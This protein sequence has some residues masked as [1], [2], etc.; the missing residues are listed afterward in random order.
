MA[1]ASV[2]SGIR[3]PK[4]HFPVEGPRHEAQTPFVLLSPGDRT[5]IEEDHWCLQCVTGDRRLPPPGSQLTPRGGTEPSMLRL[6]SRL[7]GLESGPPL[8][9]G[10]DACI[11]AVP[12]RA[13][14]LG[15]ADADTQRGGEEA[16]VNTNLSTRPSVL[17]EL[18]LL[19]LLLAVSLD[20]KSHEERLTGVERTCLAPIY[21]TQ[22]L[23]QQQVLRQQQQQQQE[24]RWD[25]VCADF[26]KFWEEEPDARKKEGGERRA[27]RE[28]TTSSSS[29]RSSNSNSNSNS[30]SGS[31]GRRCLPA[32][33][34][35]TPRDWRGPPGAPKRTHWLQLEK[36]KETLEWRRVKRE[37]KEETQ[38]HIRFLRLANPPTLHA[39]TQPTPLERAD[40]ELP[41]GCSLTPAA[42]AAAAAA[43]AAAAV[44]AGAAASAAVAAAAD[45]AAAAVAVAAA[46][47]VVS[48]GPL[49]GPCKGALHPAAEE[50]PTGRCP[51]TETVLLSSSAAAAAA[52]AA[53]A[54]AAAVCCSSP[55]LKQQFA[56]A[57]ACDAAASA[58]LRAELLGLQSRGKLGSHDPHHAGLQDSQSLE[59]ERLHRRAL[60]RV[61][62][63]AAAG[64]Q[65]QQLQQ[66]GSVK[67]PSISSNSSSSSNGRHAWRRML[68]LQLGP[69][70]CLS[71]ELEAAHHL[72]QDIKA[73]LLSREPQTPSRRSTGSSGSSEAQA[74]LSLPLSTQATEAAT[75]VLSETLE[76][77]AAALARPFEAPCPLGLSLKALRPQQVEFVSQ[78][79]ER[80]AGVLLEQE[81]DVL[82]RPPLSWARQSRFADLLRASPSVRLTYNSMLNPPGKSVH[83]AVS[84]PVSSTVPSSVSSAA[85]R[86]SLPQGPLSLRCLE[87][88]EE[89]LLLL[90]L[91]PGL[92]AGKRQPTSSTYIDP[93][94]TTCSKA[95]DTPGCSSLGAT[96]SC[97]LLA[98]PQASSGAGAAAADAAVADAAVASAT[99]VGTATSCSTAAAQLSL[100]SPGVS[101]A[102]GL[103]ETQCSSS[104]SRARDSSS[105]NDMRA[106]EKERLGTS[107][108]RPR[109][110][111][112]IEKAI[113][114]ALMRLTAASNKAAASAAAAAAG[115]RRTTTAHR[116]S[117]ASV[118]AGSWSSWRSRG[119]SAV[120][121]PAAAPP[122]APA[123][124]AAAA[125]GLPGFGG[126]PS[127]GIRRSN[128]RRPISARYTRS[129]HPRRRR[130]RQVETAAGLH[131]PVE[132]TAAWQLQ[133][134]SQQHLLR[135]QLLQHLLLKAEGK[136]R[137]VLGESFVLSL[138][139]LM[140]TIDKEIA[141]YQRY[142][143][144]LEAGLARWQQRE[145]S[146]QQ[147]LQ[148]V[149]HLRFVAASHERLRAEERQRHEE[150]EQDLTEKIE[151]LQREFARLAP[152]E[153]LIAE[154]RDR[155]EEL[156]MLLQRREAQQQVQD[157]LLLDAQQLLR[158]VTTAELLSRPQEETR[159]PPPI[160]V[161]P[162]RL[163]LFLTRHTSPSHVSKK[164]QSCAAAAAFLA[165]CVVNPLLLMHDLLI[166]RRLRMLLA[167]V[168]QGVYFCCCFLTC[169][170]CSHPSTMRPSPGPPPLLSPER[171]SS[172]VAGAYEAKGAAAGAVGLVQPPE[173]LLE[174]V[175][176]DLTLKLSADAEVRQTLASLTQTLLHQQQQQQQHHVFPASSSL[177]EA[178]RFASTQ[179][180]E[181]PAAAA[182]ASPAHQWQL[183]YVCTHFMLF[184][185]GVAVPRCRFLGVCTLD[186]YLPLPCLNI[187]L[188]VRE[189]LHERLSPRCQQQQASPASPPA[190]ANRQIGGA[191]SAAAAA[192]VKARPLSAAVT[193]SAG[194]EA[195]ADAAWAQDASNSSSSSSTSNSSS[196]NSSSR[197]SRISNSSSNSST[198]LSGVDALEGSKETAAA[199]L[200]LGTARCCRLGYVEGGFASGVR[201]PRKQ[202]IQLG[203]PRSP[204]RS[205]AAST[206]AATEE[207]KARLLLCGL[208]HR[209]LQQGRLKT[210][211]KHLNVLEAADSKMRNKADKSLHPP[212]SP[213]MTLAEVQ[214]GWCAVSAAP[215][216]S[217]SVRSPPAAAAAAAAFPS[218]SRQQ[219]S[220]DEAA[221]AMIVEMESLYDVLFEAF[222]ADFAVE[223]KPVEDAYKAVSSEGQALSPFSSFQDF[224]SLVVSTRIADV[225]PQTL[226]LVYREMQRLRDCCTREQQIIEAH[227]CPLDMQ[228]PPLDPAAADAVS[229]L[230]LRYAAA[231]TGWLVRSRIA[232][233][234]L[235]LF[236]PSCPT[237][238]LLLLLLL[239]LFVCHHDFKPCWC[240]AAKGRLD[241]GV[242]LLL[243]R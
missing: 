155:H 11:Q 185:L 24:Q 70:T 234:G 240:W 82:L 134:Q 54:S 230:L 203:S 44:A 109:D 12:A 116:P 167:V 112:T 157:G 211:Q 142:M 181:T 26:L 73:E 151:E 225:T 100:T 130:G 136:A 163:R 84:V 2:G 179:Q 233:A 145:V 161:L 88:Y 29:G 148:Q 1:R 60:A 149:Q 28:H 202:H 27:K 83:S 162:P 198:G 121:P 43:A 49:C 199:A 222:I 147:L 126:V 4:D 196:N 31:G 208:L 22:Q 9:F 75:A 33:V 105:G 169:C 159:W 65:H 102:V 137:V 213:F 172:I 77:L 166:D 176:R 19:L 170:C 108:S 67:K 141:A 113:T 224:H 218:S 96:T 72:V 206:A 106:L 173:C 53:A 201:S 128:S 16:G 14:P 3:P 180:N 107:R 48:H 129:L 92:A 35:P 210:L 125:A 58:T 50:T 6:R 168:A 103:E 13:A 192:A 59:A 143:G 39:P 110:T 164:S 219:A 114:K 209:R 56:T 200:L 52:A 120:M 115:D 182:A 229:L 95:V 215:G 90:G 86:T 139:A 123:A 104:S 8:D 242:G 189:Q 171:L 69:L 156:V 47:A 158:V 36:E 131:S 10:D 124:A 79:E 111:Q 191:A 221:M 195:A 188:F 101:E 61:T 197:I 133:Q 89:G 37:L 62:A 17:I 238:L 231:N 135:Q 243:W 212:N 41:S 81:E 68:L 184:V 187:F 194:S 122:A 232:A 193:Q 227:G 20:F 127:E 223:L 42:P 78:E 217:L 153:T 71:T 175:E 93:E 51:A 34:L 226:L 138:T 40:D 94:E 144:D 5:E 63:A 64:L 235:P 38:R 98:E 21:S 236:S 220:G 241:E 178:Q 214:A 205:P 74:M 99:E 23:Q 140:L 239:L 32:G 190:A 186:D 57:A 80:L 150:A 15:A 7:S 237:S 118:R 154:A 30:S 87:S 91:D 174:A 146:V 183:L 177:R 46:A 119:P 160:S 45:V 132:G 76:S 165:C 216:V 152:D 25:P 55:L 18:L 207:G 97:L 228:S 66:Q 117:T 204:R 85:F